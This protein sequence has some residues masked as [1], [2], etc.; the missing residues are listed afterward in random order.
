MTEKQESRML[1]LLTASIMQASIEGD[2]NF[3]NILKLADEVEN[4]VS[5]GN[6]EDKDVNKWSYLVGAMIQNSVCG[7]KSIGIGKAENFYDVAKL[8]EKYIRQE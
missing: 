7:P 1:S 8:A 5:A 4:I 2:R 6:K 3:E